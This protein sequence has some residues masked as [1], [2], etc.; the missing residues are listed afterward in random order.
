MRQGRHFCGH[1]IRIDFP[2]DDM[3]Y[4]A[5]WAAHDCDDWDLYLTIVADSDTSKAA[6]AYHGAAPS[7][8]RGCYETVWF[9]DVDACEFYIPH[10]GENFGVL[11]Q[12]GF[13]PVWYE[14]EWV[15]N[16]SS[17]TSWFGDW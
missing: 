8:R 11:F 10:N 6:I 15:Y 4:M 7:E 16:P 1:D 2:F 12:G 9:D 3:E 14:Y 13:H 17:Y 5:L